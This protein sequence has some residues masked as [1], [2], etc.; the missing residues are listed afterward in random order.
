MKRS[1]WQKGTPPCDGI[2]EIQVPEIGHRCTYYARFKDGE[3]A[4]GYFSP[5]VVPEWSGPYSDNN[6]PNNPRKWRGILE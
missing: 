6:D 1:E 3:W 4:D 5:D 2:W